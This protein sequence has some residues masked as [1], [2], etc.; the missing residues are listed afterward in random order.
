VSVF[1]RPIVKVFDDGAEPGAGDAF[2]GV[3]DGVE[4]DEVGTAALAVCAVG[5]AADVGGAGEA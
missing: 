2:P 4:G 3:R 5:F 1:A